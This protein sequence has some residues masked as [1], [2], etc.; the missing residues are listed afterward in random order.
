MF[1]NSDLVLN[2]AHSLFLIDSSI[3]LIVKLIALEHLALK[4]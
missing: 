3:Y 2:I 1:F 4:L